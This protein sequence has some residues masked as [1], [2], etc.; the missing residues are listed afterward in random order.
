MSRVTENQSSA[1]SPAFY[2]TKKQACRFLILYHHLTE[3]TALHGDGMILNHIRKVGCVQFDPLDVVGKNADLVLQSRC[4]QYRRGD[5]EKLLYQE[6]ALFDVWDKNMSICTIEDWPYFSRNREHFHPHCLKFSDAIEAISAHLRE[7]EFASSSDFDMDAKV[8]W[9]YGPQRLA[10]AALECMCCAGTAVVHHKKGTRRHYCLAENFIP[11]HLLAMEDPNRTDEDYHKWIVQRRINSIGLLWN[12]GGDAWLGL[13]NFKSPHRNS[14]FKTLLQE[15]QIVAVE[16]E[17]L[18]YPLYL[19]REN[20]PLLESS[21]TCPFPQESARILAPL[22]NLLWDRTLIAELF[23]FNYRWEVYVP[24]PKRKYGYYVL[25]LLC[26]DRFIG[27]IEMRVD[28][29]ERCL[30]V[31]SLWWEEGV[32]PEEH[33][34]SLERCLHRFAEFNLC[35]A[36]S[37][38]PALTHGAV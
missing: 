17:G 6:R 34:S 12:R 11:P 22:D 26:G 1:S 31:E 30:R 28:K 37:A 24:A 32:T 3:E 5:V 7:N 35:H 19:S 4:P 13:L 8:R 14:G 10:K 2:L 18:R 33:A 23:G 25:P 29:A 9:Y 20:V 27:R 36:V 21:L 16:V 38:P 15:G